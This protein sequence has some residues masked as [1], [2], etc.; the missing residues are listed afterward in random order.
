MIYAEVSGLVDDRMWA[1]FVRKSRCGVSAEDVILGICSAGNASGDFWPERRSRRGGLLV[2]V[3]KTS[4]GRKDAVSATS[5]LWRA[6]GGS[7]SEGPPQVSV[8][9]YNL[10]TTSYL[11]ARYSQATAIE[12]STGSRPKA[13]VTLAPFIRNKTKKRSQKNRQKKINKT[14]RGRVP[15]RTPLLGQVLNR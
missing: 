5:R 14:S 3:M 7:I 6:A 13:M 1:A 15:K 9:F 11:P 12:G 4:G 8:H 10:D 2:K